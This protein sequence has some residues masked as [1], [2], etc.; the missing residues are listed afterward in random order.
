MLIEHATVIAYADGIAEV[1]CFAKQGCGSCT[2]SSSC[3]SRALSALAG[4]KNA[5]RFR[6][7]VN[8]ALQVGDQIRLG[9]PEQTLLSG[10]LW[11]YGLPLLSLIGAVTLFSALTDN[12]IAVTFCSAIVTACSFMIAKKY[13]HSRQHHHQPRFLGRV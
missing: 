9:L 13:L 6:L 10:M 1:Q 7:P 4:E 11:L 5:P 8:E 2:A 3:G 12:E